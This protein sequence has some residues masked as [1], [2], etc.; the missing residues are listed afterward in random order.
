MIYVFS[1]AAGRDALN[2]PEARPF[3][4][5][6]IGVNG[7]T[8]KGVKIVWTAIEGCREIKIPVDIYHEAHYDHEA[9][10]STK[11][12]CAVFVVKEM[13]KRGLITF[14]ILTQEVSD[15][16]LQIRG[17][18]LTVMSCD[19][20]IQIKCDAWASDF[21]LRLQTAECNPYQRH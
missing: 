10:T 13:L 19:L 16:D 12:K 14:P 5:N 20:K 18:D 17:T 1:T 4:V 3:E 8:G 15:K 6:Q 7:I 11:G 2:S 21:G 9:D